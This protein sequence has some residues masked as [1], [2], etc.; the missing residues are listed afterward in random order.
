M[1]N[2]NRDLQQRVKTIIDEL[3]DHAD[4]PRDDTLCLVCR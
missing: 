1:L 4:S 2:L 3:A